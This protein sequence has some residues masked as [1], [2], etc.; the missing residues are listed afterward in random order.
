MEM[1]KKERGNV[2]GIEMYRQN[3]FFKKKDSKLT[4][5]GIAGKATDCEY[6]WTGE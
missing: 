2:G 5:G 1:S 6:R 4:N 3:L